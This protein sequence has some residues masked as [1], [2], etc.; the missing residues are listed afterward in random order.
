MDARKNYPEIVFLN[1]DDIRPYENSTRVHG[2]KQLQALKNS[3]CL[4]GLQTPLLIDENNVTID[5]HARYQVCQALN[6]EQI[7]VIRVTGLS[8]EDK[9]LLRLTL[10][11]L[12]SQGKTDPQKLSLELQRLKIKGA[13]LTLIGAPRYMI[14]RRLAGTAP[15]ISALD[16]YTSS[17]P[18]TIAG[19]IW[20]C[21]ASQVRCA[22]FLAPDSIRHGVG[23]LQVAFA[24]YG[25]GEAAISANS[26]NPASLDAMASVLPSFAPLLRARAVACIGIEVSHLPAIAGSG[27]EYFELIDICAR[28]PRENAETLLRGSDLKPHFIFRRTSGSQTPDAAEDGAV[29]AFNL[30]KP[31]RKIIKSSSTAA[32]LLSDLILYYTQRGDMILDGSL[33]SGTSLL[34]AERPDRLCIGFDPCP[35]RVNAPVRRCQQ[36]TGKYAVHTAASCHSMNANFLGRE[37]NH[38][39]TNVQQRR[40][41][42]ERKDFCR[43]QQIPADTHAIQARQKRQSERA[44]QGATKFRS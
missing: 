26:N 36:L 9:R 31:R 22:D 14:E 2:P 17:S 1:I 18:V 7:P 30:R 4:Q 24:C 5:G 35:T 27:A 37:P 12:S 38:R 29:A 6:H 43:R 40:Y 13:N 16:S 3:V 10:A 28:V 21:D 11:E 34:A 8:E 25:F 44:S 23:G 41:H 19:D 15:R 42:G 33:G 39:P 32:A 20:L